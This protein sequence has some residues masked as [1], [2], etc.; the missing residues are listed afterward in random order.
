MTVGSSKCKCLIT[1]VINSVVAIIVRYSYSTFRDEPKLA[2]RLLFKF[3]RYKTLHYRM[4]PFRDEDSNFG[5]SM[6]VEVWKRSFRHV[7]FEAVQVGYRVTKIILWI[8]D[9]FGFASTLTLTS[10][11]A[12]F[13]GEKCEAFFTGVCEE[14][15]KEVF[16]MSCHNSN[17]SR[18]SN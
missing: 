5:G 14:G 13:P 17:A 3:F 12:K 18:F 8:E 7:R 10:E 9:A 1:P 6:F 4:D 11:W 15:V 2:V 16:L